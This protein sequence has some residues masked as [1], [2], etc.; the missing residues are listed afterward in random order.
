[1]TSEDKIPS[2]LQQSYFLFNLVISPKNLI[3]LGLQFHAK[4]PVLH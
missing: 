2:I 1:M 3:P 4:V